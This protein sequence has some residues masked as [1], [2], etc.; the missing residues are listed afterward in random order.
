MSNEKKTIYATFVLAFDLC[1]VMLSMMVAHSKRMGC[2]LLSQIKFT[3]LSQ[4][5]LNSYISYSSH[6]YGSHARAAFLKNGLR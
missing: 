1:F 4:T 2:K 5:S 3:V 6:P